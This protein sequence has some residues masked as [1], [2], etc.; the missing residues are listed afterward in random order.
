MVLEAVWYY[1]Q[2]GVKSSMV[3]QAVWYYTQYDITRSMVLQQYGITSIQL[4][5]Y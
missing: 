2:Y 1:R 4:R 3:L 5:V